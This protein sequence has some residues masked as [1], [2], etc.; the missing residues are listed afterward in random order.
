MGEDSS[1]CGMHRTSLRQFEYAKAE[2][3]LF[4]FSSVTTSITTY[5]KLYSQN[6]LFIISEPDF[7]IDDPHIAKLLPR[8]RIKFV[9]CASLK[10]M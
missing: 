6:I 9:I 2:F 3:P 10:C 5:L 7:F 1:C 4:I 8:S